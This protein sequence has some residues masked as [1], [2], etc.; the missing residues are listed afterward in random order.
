[1]D[2]DDPE[3][4]KYHNILKEKIQEK[5]DDGRKEADDELKREAREMLTDFDEMLAT[6]RMIKDMAY[7]VGNI[8]DDEAKQLE[9]EL[10]DK[11]QERKMGEDIQKVWEARAVE[12]MAE[13]KELLDSDDASDENINNTR[14]AADEA[15]KWAKK[16][17]GRF[18]G[19][20]AEDFDDFANDLD[21][22]VKSLLQPDATQLRVRAAIKRFKKMLEDDD[23][24][25]RDLLEAAAE[26][27]E[28]VA[29]L[30]GI[31]KYCK[32]HRDCKQYKSLLK[33]RAVTQQQHIV[34]VVETRYKPLQSKFMLMKKWL[35]K[36][37]VPADEVKAVRR[38][39][40]VWETADNH[41]LKLPL[42]I[43][44]LKAIPD[45]LRSTV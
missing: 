2:L 30:E 26:A 12:K 22:K 23:A 28:F 36:H 7:K 29:E 31:H 14:Q 38:I 44:G 8:G 16:S 33:A 35:T 45:D 17:R 19:V 37:G 21:E 9:Q 6:S 25:P 39:F 32:G 40:Q 15:R 20:Y 18:K 11:A 41:G 42:T 5:K 13:F 10:R 34:R 4:M 27:K 1:M 43:E 24:F 3:V